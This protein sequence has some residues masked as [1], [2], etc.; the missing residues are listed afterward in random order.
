LRYCVP[1][2]EGF[3]GSHPVQQI[4]GQTISRVPQ[5]S[6]SVSHAL[7]GRNFSA[8]RLQTLS[9][10]APAR[11]SPHHRL[12]ITK[13][14]ARLP[15]IP[16][17]ADGI[18]ANGC[19]QLARLRLKSL[20]SKMEK[21]RV[22]PPPWTPP[23]LPL[24]RSPTAPLA[25][26]APSILWDSWWATW[27]QSGRDCKVG[28]LQPV[29]SDFF[30]CTVPL[31]PVPLP[32]H[33]KSSARTQPWWPIPLPLLGLRQLSC[34]VAGRILPAIPNGWR[35]ANSQVTLLNWFTML[36]RVLSFPFLFLDRRPLN[37]LLLMSSA[38]RSVDKARSRDVV[39]KG[40][41]YSTVTHAV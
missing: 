26:A 15:R 8:A 24:H 18:K 19:I 28:T 17:E 16:A 5:Y 36:R 39:A 34:C 13:H 41:G 2:P 21:D 20:R 31:N 4:G 23:P 35:L 9:F 30:F 32:S 10:A 7:C 12:R 6:S 27:L 29:C 33:D 14:S 1:G 37:Q 3:A 22:E 11:S 25:T 38:M 40:S